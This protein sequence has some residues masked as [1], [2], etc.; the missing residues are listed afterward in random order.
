MSKC[1]KRAIGLLF[2]GS[3]YGQ[4]IIY[5][6]ATHIESELGV[7]FAPKKRLALASTQSRK[8]W[9][10]LVGEV[11]KLCIH[12]C[13]N[14]P[15]E[16]EPPW[17]GKPPVT[18]CVWNPTYE[19]YE[20][21]KELAEAY[22]AGELLGIQLTIK[23]SWGLETSGHFDGTYILL[24]AEAP[25]PDQYGCTWFLE[26]EFPPFIPENPPIVVMFR[27]WF[28]DEYGSICT[29]I[30][31]PDISTGAGDLGNVF[32]VCCMEGECSLLGNCLGTPR[33]EPTEFQPFWDGGETEI[34]W[35]PIYGVP[36]PPSLP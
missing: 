3:E 23:N 14:P 16:Q 4:I 31:I 25:Y 15:E 20:C 33:P 30:P 34:S 18:G 2:A 21:C 1:G 13:C 12:C 19:Y 36:I 10:R 27:V 28:C 22:V 7:T 32:N 9:T 8:L 35:A 6:K 24:H 5:S 17:S 29:I 26:V 11:R